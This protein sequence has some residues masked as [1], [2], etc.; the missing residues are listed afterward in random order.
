MSDAVR[1]LANDDP[2]DGLAPAG[3]AVVTNAAAGVTSD[4]RLLIGI[5]WDG[6]NTTCTFLGSY[7][8]VVNDRVTFLKYGPSMVVLGKPAT[9]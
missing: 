7:T 5:R 3:T 1:R 9:T 2:N 6:T 8:P 4:G